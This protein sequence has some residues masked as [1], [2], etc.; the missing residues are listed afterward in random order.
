MTHPEPVQIEHVVTDD[1]ELGPTP[2]RDNDVWHMV[3][4]ESGHTMWRRVYLVT[5][6]QF[7]RNE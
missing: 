4:R 7:S 5:H 2:P 3:R 1:D 6:T